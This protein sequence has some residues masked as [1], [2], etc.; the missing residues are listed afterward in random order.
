MEKE[1]K[2]NSKERSLRIQ[3]PK[4]Y[5][6]IAAKLEDYHV[7]SYDVQINVKEEES[8]H[9]IVLHYGNGY[10][11]HLSQVFT[12]KQMYEMDT[13]ITDFVQKSVDTIKEVMVADYFKMMKV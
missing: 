12:P 10:S 11:H 3:F 5:N 8:Y 4:L 9:C 2:N 6:H 13:E 7:H 1:D